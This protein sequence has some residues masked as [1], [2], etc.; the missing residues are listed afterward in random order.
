MS[1][2]TSNHLNYMDMRRKASS[3]TAYRAKIPSSNGTTFSMSQDI[4]FD[5]P[6]NVRNTYLDFSSSY[7]SLQVQNNDGSA[8]TLP[9]QG[10][11]AII[12][13]LEII[14]S[15]QTIASID[16]YNQLIDILLD[17]DADVDY[18][19]NTGGVLM[20]TA[21]N[22]FTGTDIANGGV[23]QFCFPLP[24][25]LLYETNKYIPLFS[26]EKLRI[27]LTL[28][29]SAIAFKGAATDAEVVIK[30]VEFV[31]YNILL[32]EEVQMQV[33]EMTGG[34]YSILGDNY[35][36]TSSVSAATSTSS[37]VQTGFSYGSLNR[38]LACFRPT[39]CLV[40]GRCSFSRSKNDFSSAALTI[41]GT[42]VPRSEIK[43]PT[44]NGAEVFA[45]ILVADKC[46]GN[47][48]HNSSIEANGAN[49]FIRQGTDA[50][51]NTD[52]GDI[53]TFY[54]GI[55]CQQMTGDLDK[56]YAGINTIGSS[57]AL[58][59]EMG[60]SSDAVNIHV[61]G[62][63]TAKFTLDTNTSNVWEVQV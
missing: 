57:V 52:A 62:Q 23:E 38:V 9:G 1:E 61:F 43:D 29:S 10:I 42:K 8:I 30:Q 34:V 35:V 4:I 2:V 17:Q 28:D 59:L 54:I 63:Y 14:S 26:S 11:Y 16:N 46:L 15:S 39:A 51:S 18:K 36:H 60:S 47:F 56:I 6:S 21:T 48:G 5:L 58:S 41:N 27:K 32:D 45:E 13:K 50:D 25:N 40:A 49:S 31:T 3:S 22:K 12:K 44:G 53:G 33:N 20:G 55:D 24:G 37:N 19:N 7:V